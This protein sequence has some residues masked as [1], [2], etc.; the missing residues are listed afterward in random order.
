[1][2]IIPAVDLKD[3]L[4]VRGIGGR[5]E[6]YR[7]I[8]SRLTASCHPV[9]VA[10]AYREHFGLD[11]IYLADLNALAGAAPSLLVYSAIQ[12]EGFRL[13]VDAGVR[14][15]ADARPLTA[16][17]GIVAGLETIADPGVLEALCREFGDHIYFSLDLK[18]GRP[19]GN[20]AAWGETDPWSIAVRA[21]R[22]GIR[23]LIV[24]DLAQVGMNAGAGT[25]AL[26]SRLAEA[27]PHVTLLAGGGVRGVDDLHRMRRCGIHAALVASALH[28]G[29]LSRQDLEHFAREA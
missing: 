18:E 29:R 13:L 15:V 25:E 21:I 26:C 10:C 9:D 17:D 3:G 8:V 14:E 23:N 27:F 28:D 1:M 20:V 11:E 24:L 6:K 2:R 7:P 5:R 4:V 12:A 22:G 16:V 19:L